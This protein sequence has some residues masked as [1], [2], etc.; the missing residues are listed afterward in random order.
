MSAEKD[1]LSATEAEKFFGRSLKMMRRQAQNGVIPAKQAG[2]RWFFHKAELKK[3][4]KSSG[5]QVSL[6]VDESPWGRA[7][8]HYID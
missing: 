8:R 7:I 3:W 5:P 6:D 2:R 4:L 1:A